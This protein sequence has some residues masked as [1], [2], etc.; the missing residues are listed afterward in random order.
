MR[1]IFKPV[2][3]LSLAFIALLAV[4]TIVAFP[5]L[6]HAGWLFARY[7]AL[8]LALAL[9]ALSAGRQHASPFVHAVHAFLPV[10]IVPVIFD[11]MGD[12]IPWVRSRTI[13][14]LLISIDFRLFGGRHPTVLLERFIH[15]L[16]TTVLQFAYISYYPMAITLGAVLFLKKNETAF[17][18]AIFGVILCFYLS[19]LGYLLFPAIGPRF[20]L[21]HLQT[22]D[23]AASP[24]VVA[25]QETL[26]AL[27]NTKADAFPSGHT[28][29]ALMT[30]YYAVKFREWVLIV[31]LIPAV[32]GL[33][34]STVYLRYHYVIDVIAGLAL[35]ALTI[36]LAPLLYELLLRASRGAS[37]QFHRTP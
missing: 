13:D 23:L 34:V 30:L 20:T 15:P 4:V 7:T 6:P 29:I 8:L 36:Y 24:L 19:Y 31:I 2:D 10:L 17:G 35:T 18:E 22:R 14:D 33:I 5:R 1:R 3:L 26:N 32:T 37:D 9:V 16:L 11:S 28:A 27:E 21:V 12:L 25:I